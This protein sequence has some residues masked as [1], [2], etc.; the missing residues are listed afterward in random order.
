MNT[1]PD[2]CEVEWHIE[3]GVKRIQAAIERFNPVA[4]YGLFSGGHDSLAATYIASRHPAFTAAVH[5]NTGI[6]VSQTRDFVRDT[7]ENRGWPLLEYKA[8]ENTT[9]KG[10]PDPQDYKELVR[11]FGFPGP[12]S[13]GLMYNKL[14]ERQIRR[15]L[16]DTKTKRNQKVMLI[17]GCRSQESVRRMGNVEECQKDGAKIWVAP[18]HD[19]SKTEC[20]RII[21]YASL[22]R[23][24]VVDLIHKSGEC[25]C[26]AFAKPGELDELEMWFPETAAEIRT[27]EA[28]LMPKFGWSWEGKPQKKC[29]VTK[30]AGMLCHNC[31]IEGP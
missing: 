10:V 14:K 8:M 28:E 13:H 21:Q 6:G 22:K 11:R 20:G 29:K 5:I 18:I 19:L 4:I 30:E 15:L 9:A 27:L 12:G 3:L 17:S 23:N 2:T 16:R 7:C 24:P 1:T 25:L 26:G 31:N